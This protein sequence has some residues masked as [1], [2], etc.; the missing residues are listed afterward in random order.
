MNDIL[1]KIILGLSLLILGGSICGC[2][3]VGNHDGVITK[4]TWQVNQATSKIAVL[5]GVLDK[6]EEAYANSKS[7]D[8]RLKIMRDVRKVLEKYESHMFDCQQSDQEKVKTTQRRIEKRIVGL[9]LSIQIASLENQM[10]TQATDL[11]KADIC[12]KILWLIADAPTKLLP[13]SE[14]SRLKAKSRYYT[15]LKIG[16]ACSYYH[17]RAFIAYEKAQSFDEFCNVANECLKIFSFELE[18]DVL[19]DKERAYLKERR[20]E[21]VHL[22]SK[23]ISEYEYILSA[24]EQ[25]ID[26]AQADYINSVAKQDHK[27][28]RQ[29]YLAEKEKYFNFFRWRDNVRSLCTAVHFLDRIGSDARVDYLLRRQAATMRHDIY[30]ERFDKGDRKRFDSLPELPTYAKLDGFPRLDKKVLA[31]CASERWKELRDSEFHPELGQVVEKPKF[32][33]AKNQ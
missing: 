15:R 12:E 21:V 19:T 10:E 18:S 23:A 16:Y 22:L 30:E 28:A 7:D 26:A 24:M 20:E 11:A 3:S 8:E 33:L 27:H 25:D 1:K 32:Q 4:T 31:L 13:A 29:L 14:V 5:R 9:E 6:H 2:R 17:Q